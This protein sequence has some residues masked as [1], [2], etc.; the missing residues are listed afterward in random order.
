MRLRRQ[1]GHAIL[2]LALS[3]AVMASCLGGTFQFG[4]SFYVY[5][6]LVSAVGNAGRYAASRT[7]RAA[8]PEDVEK[9]EAAIRN[10]LVY[11]DAR[12]APDAV[13]VVPGLAPENVQVTWVAGET[14]EAPSAVDVAIV[15][16]TVRAL[17]GSL[18]LDQR[19]AVE[20]PFLGRYAPSESEP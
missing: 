16:Y 12:P 17:F 9:G 1:G 6:Q 18:T 4:Y 13:P 8:A 2:E 19:P 15:H 14:G 20:F 10:L 5:D 7:Y 11:G 3:A